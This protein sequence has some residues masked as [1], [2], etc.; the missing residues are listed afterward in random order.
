MA[1]NYSQNTRLWNSCDVICSRGCLGRGFRG[2]AAAGWL[3]PSI[4]QEISYVPQNL[5][6][7]IG[8]LC[9]TEKFLT[10]NDFCTT[11]RE[12]KAWEDLQRKRK[13][14]QSN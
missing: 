9:T 14:G 1:F 12:D 7:P 2:L 4:T 8:E 10:P 3:S 5:K 11:K 6:K 13:I